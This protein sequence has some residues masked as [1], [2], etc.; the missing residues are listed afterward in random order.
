MGVPHDTLMLPIHISMKKL[1]ITPQTCWQEL[2]PLTVLLGS[3][4]DGEPNL[5]DAPARKLYV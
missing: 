1:F 2:K 4:P 3:K 5:W